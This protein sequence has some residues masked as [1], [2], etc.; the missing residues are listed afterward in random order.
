MIFNNTAI[1]FNK[2][3]IFVVLKLNNV[4]HVLTKTKLNIFASGF[5]CY[6]KFGLGVG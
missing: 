1:S 2:A 4:N 5:L 6:V 3:V